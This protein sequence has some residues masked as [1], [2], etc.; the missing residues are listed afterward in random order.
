MKKYIKWGGIV[1]ASP[2]ILFIVLCILIYIPAVQN[3]IVDKA[4]FYAS[5]ATG[6]NIHIQRISLSFPLNLVVHETTVTNPQDTLLNVEKLTVK[7]QLLPLV[8]KQIEID[9]VELKNASVNTVDLIEGMSLQGNLGELFLK[10]HGVDLTPETAILNELTLKDANLKLCLAD[11]TAQDTT[12]STPTFWKFKL[13]KIDLANVDFQMDMPLDSM[14]LGLTVGNASLRDGLVD[15]HKAAYSAKEFKLL[16]SGLYYNSG[17]TPPIE[18][19]LDPS[20]IAVTDINLQMDSLY[21]QG[22]NIRALLHQFELKERSGLEIKSTE[23]QLQ[24]DEK[25]IR[26]PSLQIKTANSFLALKATID[27]SVTEQ[28]QDGVLNGQFIAEIGKADLFKLIPDMP[29]E[30]IQSFPAAPLQVRIGVDGSLSD[31]KLTTCQVK[32]PDCFR[33]EMD[34]TA[35]NVLDS[36]SREGV[37]NLNSDFYKMDFLSSLTG[38]V[39]IPSGMNIHGKAGMKGN[40]LFTETTLSQHE[41]KVQ[42]NAEY[43]LLKE[44]YKADIQINEL[45]LHDF[46][47]ADSLFYLSAGMQLEGAGTDIFSKQ[48]TLTANAGLNH[49]QW[50]T[51]IFSGVQLNAALKESK[52]NLN[53]DVNDNLMN[54]SSQLDA[55]LHPSAIAA[56]MLIQVKNLDLYGMGLLN[57]PLKTTENIDIQLKTDMKK[58]HGVR[59]SVKDINLITEKKTFK[60][61]DIHFGFSTA[62]DSIRSYANAGDLTFLFRSRGG[63]DELGS[64]VTKLTDAL[65]TQWK[66]KSIDQVALRELWPE[67]QFRI[68]AGKD[69]PISNTLAIK[70]I[71]F[72][73]MNVNIR[74]SPAEGLNASMNLYGLRTDSLAFDTIYFN[75]TQQ[76]E[77]ILFS[78][79]VIAN[80]KPFQEAFDI[81]LNGDIGA[82]KANATI[83]YLNGKKECGVNIGMVAGL[84]KGGISLHITPFDPILV[85]RKFT[86]NPDNYI[87][88]RDDGRIMANLSIYDEL[89]TGLS[90]YSTPDSTARQDLTL[91]LS[92]IN[93]GEFKRVIPYMPDIEGIINS[94]AHYVQT[95]EGMDQISLENNI[96]KLSY[97]GIALGNWALSAVYLPKQSGEQHIN[98]LIMQNDN[99]IIS[100]EGSYFPAEKKEQTED[101][102]DARM[103]LHHFPLEIAN[104]FIPGKMAML[105]GD[106]DGTMHMTGNASQPLMNGKINLDSVNIYVPQASLNLRFD[107]KPV[108]IKDSKLTFNRFKIFTKGKTPFTIDGDVDMADFSQMK[109]N[110]KMDANNFELLNAKQTKQSLVYGKLYVDFH[111]TLKG[112]PDNMNIRGNMNILGTSNFTYILQD[113]PLTVED[114]LGETV[115]FTNFSD[116][117]SIQ[118]RAL[119]ALSLGGIDMLMTLH[120]DEGVQC[121]VN[122]DEKGSNYM[123]FEGGGDLSFQ[124]TPEGNIILNGRYS[125]LSG[126]MKYQLPIIQLKTFHIQS[127]SYIQWSG[128][129]MNPL[130][131]IKAT[132][133]VRSSVAQEG[134]ASRM[135]NFD[136]GVNITN[137]LENLGFTFIIDAPDD[138]TMQNELASMSAE[139]KNKVAVTMLV[140]GMYLT[141][142][143][144]LG[145]GG[146]SV[147]NS[148]LQDQI[149]KVAGSA[150]KTID[151]NFGIETNNEEETG[152]TST[153]YNFQFAKRFWN[154]RIRVVIGGKVSTGNNVQQ[155]ESFIDNIS[156]EYRL[157]N[158]GTRYVKLFHDKNYESV[159]D[160]EVIETGAGIVLR[161]K[162]SKVGELF[163]FR[164]KKRPQPESEKKEEDENEEEKNK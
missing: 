17:N 160:G 83:E 85:Y 75:A 72:D 116:T 94:E 11:T 150:L 30:F 67:T 9:G 26:V 76:P 45:N 111:S 40:D 62:R 104:S 63:I 50:G 118:R 37:I 57:S 47:P 126:E 140:T 112:T 78:S 92:Q 68:F 100:I 158:S 161:K 86:V 58:S 106:I 152:Q 141:E 155:D 117:T 13:E 2:F 69:N 125:L 138:G 31:L 71:N 54:I 88:L 56:D 123:Y 159:L 156:L 14:N 27:W 147:M 5:Q 43:N 108:E 15:L 3:F 55:S 153:D 97:N 49:L 82:D 84:Q 20:H 135:V 70:K 12:Q 89:R 124:Y 39:V 133:R 21:Y 52:A 51:R 81:M 66:Q 87:Y 148:F 8:K 65:S 131:S 42:L 144:T 34:G 120:I 25:A 105:S 61:K 109:M 77:K 23:G 4:T 16:Q 130:M 115:T 128:N 41:G 145:G 90:F 164:K 134:Q 146:S 53:L 137:T 7:I 142:G 38:G 33:M 80:D 1:L 64:Q 93:I 74:T 102:I 48:T 44:A 22:N 59:L 114:R 98:G 143:S 162:V 103:A 163:I 136:V 129:A 95:E 96:N 122:M 157:D 110:L 28:N 35:K 139:E 73:R 36:L 119:P 29:Q 91:S 151:V 60:T 79:G 18:K 101:R 6:M 19:G 149:S 127:G 46:L 99:E 113:S 10:S 121:R 32:I 132:E 154:N 107:D 24:A